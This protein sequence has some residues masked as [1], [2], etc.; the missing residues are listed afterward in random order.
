MEKLKEEEKMTFE[1]AFRALEESA[2]KLR[3]GALGLEESIEVYDKSIM[4]YNICSEIL[5]N[6]KQKILVCS[7]TGETEEFK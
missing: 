1:Q 5:A 6:A 3:S 4:Y 7:E 2:E